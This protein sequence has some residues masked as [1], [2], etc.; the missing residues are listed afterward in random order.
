MT[1]QFR[2][3]LIGTAVLLTGYLTT[4]CEKEEGEGGRSSISGRVIEQRVAPASDEV[5]HEYNA[6]DVRVYIIYG[7]EDE[8]YD[9]DM[10]TD[11]QGRY[12][13][14]WLR[15]GTYT[16]YVYSECNLNQ[17][18]D[19]DCITIGGEYPEIRTIDLDKNQD[20]VVD[21]II[22]KNY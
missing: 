10:R 15:P 7:P 12:R 22:I 20:F 17:N 3:I 6:Q 14:Q 21:D 11:F 4:G 9:D 2:N 1:F 18:L 13:F 19:P 5:L 8:V 16:I